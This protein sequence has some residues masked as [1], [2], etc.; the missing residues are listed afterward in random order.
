[1]KNEC[2]A[3][4]LF[5]T[6]A[7]RAQMRD[8]FNSI[9][10]KIGHTFHFLAHLSEGGEAVVHRVVA[11]LVHEAGVRPGVVTVV[12]QRQGPGT[13]P[14]MKLMIMKTVMTMEMMMTCNTF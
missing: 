13:E 9:S 2:A 11:L 3:F 5:R 14:A 8:K 7:S 6:F 4:S 12:G 1:M 10:I